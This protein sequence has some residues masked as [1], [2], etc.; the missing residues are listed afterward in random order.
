M[1][2]LYFILF[3]LCCSTI[4]MTEM[5][6]AMVTNNNSSVI[7]IEPRDIDFG[8]VEKGSTKTDCFTV[9]NTGYDAFTFHL[10]YSTL[11][12]IFSIPEGG[13]EYV[14]NAG[15]FKTFTLECTVPIDYEYYGGGI[16]VYIKSNASNATDFDV[17]MVGFSVVEPGF[18]KG[19]AVYNNGTLTFYYDELKGSREGESY[20]LN[21]QYGTPEWLGVADDIK[22]VVF[23]ASFVEARPTTTYKWFYRMEELTTIEGI[24]NLNTSQVTDMED[25]FS[26]CK[27]LT[28]LDLSNFDTS[29]VTNM[30]WMFYSCESL[31]SVN[32]SSFDTSKVTNMSSMFMFCFS[33]PS[34]DVSHFNTSNV[35][36]ASQMF[37]YCNALTNLDISNFDFS[38]C[39]NS[40]RMV[41]YCYQLKS[42][43]ISS[44]MEK[45]DDSACYGV[46][47]SSSPCPLIAPEGFDF[48]VDTSGD[49]FLWKGGYFYLWDSTSS[50]YLITD[51][52][53]KYNMGIVGMLVGTDDSPY[54]TVLHKFG[55][56]LAD[57]VLEVHF[58]NNS[59]YAIKEIESDKY[60]DVVKRYINNQLILIGASGTVN[61]YSLA[62]AIVASVR[63]RGQET[64]VD[65]SELP[66][67]QYIVNCGEQSFKFNKK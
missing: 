24:E 64:V 45:L 59:S 21:E 7:K 41:Y 4:Q 39:V 51:K 20:E 34:L 50:W 26:T 62:G 65:V 48:G 19:Y 9:Y 8:N 56:I 15:D 40:E 57:E 18:E 60:Q 28:F 49:Y 43:Y 58:Q 14:L 6:K 55:G 33:L 42:L 36:S 63:V 61:I 67:G 29:N 31:K 2:K 35:V 23:D 38:K 52:E 25:M 22:K 44:T 16:A 30:S 11:D 3:L 37:D 5:V 46:G 66:S 1:K 17:V 47:S 32:V 53:E 54:F 12:G 10:D 13:E 27:K